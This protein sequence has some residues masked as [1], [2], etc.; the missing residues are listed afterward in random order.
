M[1]L[2]IARYVFIDFLAL[3]ILHYVQNAATR[4]ATRGVSR[5]VGGEPMQIIGLLATHPCS[6]VRVSKMCLGSRRQNNK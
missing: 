1:L 5:T 6:N 2:I 3:M 4:F